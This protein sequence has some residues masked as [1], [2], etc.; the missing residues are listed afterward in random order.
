MRYKVR[1]NRRIMDG[2]HNEPEPIRLSGESEGV[3]TD[4][5]ADDMNDLLF[6][7]M[8]RK[9]QGDGISEEFKRDEQEEFID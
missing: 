8:H 1:Y 6:D 4:V 3:G 9:V 2:L 5:T 7:E